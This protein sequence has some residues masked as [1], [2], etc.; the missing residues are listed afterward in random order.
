MAT[1]IKGLDADIDLTPHADCLKGQ[2]FD[3]AIRYYSTL[4]AS[5][6]LSLDEAQALVKAGLQLGAVCNPT[7]QS[8]FSH[9]KGVAD[10]TAAYHMAL[11][12]IGQPADSAIYLR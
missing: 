5:K 6:S 3:F 12:T 1:V 11:D 9:A 7:H 4:K 10:G 8:F 2:G